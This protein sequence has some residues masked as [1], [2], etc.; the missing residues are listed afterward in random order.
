MRSCRFVAVACAFSV[1]AMALMA[2]SL[3]AGISHLVFGKVLDNSGNA[4]GFVNISVTK[5]STGEILVTASNAQGFYQADLSHLSTGYGDGDAMSMMAS[6]GIFSVWV[7]I[8]VDASV[9][10]QYV[11]LIIPCESHTI[12]GYVRYPWGSPAVSFPVKISDMTLGGSL[13]CTSNAT[14]GLYREDLAFIP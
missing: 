4:V 9:P 13:D 5:I 14:T 8:T 3:G 6:Y 11:D 12:S 1:A 2:P 10:S 7:N